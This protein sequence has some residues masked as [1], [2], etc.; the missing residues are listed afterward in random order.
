M[1]EDEDDEEDGEDG[2]EAEWGS[3]SGETERLL[4]G[5]LLGEPRGDE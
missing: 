5:L 3:G 4:V 1:R 2:G